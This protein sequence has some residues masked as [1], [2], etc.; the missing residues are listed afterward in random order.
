MV[1]LGS[2]TMRRQLALGGQIAGVSMLLGAFMPG[3][4]GD[5][6]DGGIAGIV[7]VE[8]TASLGDTDEYEMLDAGPEDYD[9]AL[10]GGG[11]A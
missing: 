7:P 10:Q 4:F 2:P 9:E 5:N 3:A 11:I 8:A 6:G 1:P